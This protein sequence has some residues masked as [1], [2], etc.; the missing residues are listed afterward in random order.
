[1]KLPQLRIVGPGPRLEMTV[2]QLETDS[3]RVRLAQ[4]AFRPLHF[5]RIVENFD[6]DALGDCDGFF[7]D[8]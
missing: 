8:A 5:D 1:V 4:L 2:A 3:G 7:A 6:G